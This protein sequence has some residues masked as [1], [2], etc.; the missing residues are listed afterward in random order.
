MAHR[1]L[2]MCCDLLRTLL[3][4]LKACGENKKK[5]GQCFQKKVC[6]LM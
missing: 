6:S 4:D 2:I 5:V 3:H 1:V